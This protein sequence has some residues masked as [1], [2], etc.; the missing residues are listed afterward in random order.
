MRLARAAVIACSLSV[1]CGEDETTTSDGTAGGGG[2]PVVGCAPGWRPLEDGSCLPPGIPAEACGNGFEATADGGCEA[3]LPALDCGPGQIAVPGDTACRSFDDCGSGAWGNVAIDASTEHVDGAFMG[4]TSD[5]SAGS[6]HRTIGEAVIAAADGATIA[7]AQGDYA[8][9]V[10]IVGKSLTLWGRCPSL[11]EIRGD[12]TQLGVVNVTF[13]PASGTVLRGIAVSGQG[14]GVVVQGSQD[15][16]LDTVHVH[17][18]A[19]RGVNLEQGARVEVVD[20]LID[21]ASDLGTFVAGS[22]LSFHR[23]VVRNTQLGTG[24]GRG[25]DM[26]A[27]TVTNAPSDASISESLID[28]NTAVG[29]FMASA[30]ARI[31]STLIRRTQPDPSNQVG[32]GIEIQQRLGSPFPARLELVSSVLDNNQNGALI[33][34]GASVIVEHSVLSHTLPLGLGPIS[35][36]GL[37]IEMAVD[38]ITSSDVVVHESLL[39]DNGLGL[40]VAGGQLEVSSTIVRDGFQGGGI[41]VQVAYPGSLPSTATLQW[42]LLERN[43]ALGVLV[44]GSTATIESVHVRDSLP[45]PLDL[46]GRGIQIQADYQTLLPASATIR[47]SLVERAYEAGIASAG[48]ALEIASTQ[49]LDVAPEVAGHT[50]GDGIVIVNEVVPGASATITGCTVARSARAGIADFG[51]SVSLQGSNLDC[52]PIQ[53]NGEPFNG[54]GFAFTDLGGNRC[55]CNA[56]TEECAAKSSNLTPPASVQ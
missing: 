46:L 1:A 52:N 2:D 14:I 20:S 41:A 27:S 9:D 45:D 6:P 56:D 23:S 44:I 24:Y 54:Q 13:G 28:G 37:G 32:R 35:S 7:I 30:D 11:V 39:A 48:A 42:L 4:A 55:G 43:V 19:R 29:V 34:A 21:R 50:S 49:I 16:L 22:T 12:G 51:A 31:E 15:V 33:V 26:A 36:R 25:I 10:V 8:E 47:D 18:T 3:I 40:F 53:L 5:G 38:G 17:D